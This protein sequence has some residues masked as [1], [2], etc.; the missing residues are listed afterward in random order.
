MLIIRA[1]RQSMQ[2]G[3]ISRNYKWLI[4]TIVAIFIPLLV[5]QL[6]NNSQSPVKTNIYYYAGSGNNSEILGNKE[7]ECW[8]MSL[9]SSR[10]DAYRCAVDNAIYDP[11]FEDQVTDFRI[12][13]C[14]ISPYKKEYNRFKVKSFPENKNDNF[15]RPDSGAPWFVILTD[16]QECVFITGA[17]G[18]IADHRLDYQ[19]SGNTS[20]LLPVKE[21]GKVLQIGCL[22]DNRIESCEI[23][24]AWY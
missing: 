4:G 20:L 8:N 17:T 18:V 12:V 23:A 13:S 10:S 2:E 24:E 21:D 3:Y 16:K 7:A 9:S 14:P 11:C 1:I 22:K 15:L 6:E 5:Y 19:C